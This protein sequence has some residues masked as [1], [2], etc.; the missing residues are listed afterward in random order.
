MHLHIHPR[1]M[2]MNLMGGAYSRAVGTEYV[3]APTRLDSG[4]WIL[5]PGRLDVKTGGLRE[6]T[7]CLIR[8]WEQCG[9]ACG[10]RSAVYGR[11]G[12]EWWIAGITGK[13]K[14]VWILQTPEGIGNRNRDTSRIARLTF[15]RRPFSLLRC[16]SNPVPGRSSLLLPSFHLDSHLNQPSP[17]SSKKS[18]RHKDTGTHPNRHLDPS[19]WHLY[20]V[21]RAWDNRADPTGGR[22]CQTRTSRNG[23]SE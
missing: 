21:R 13:A 2:L 11:L 8:R 15:D 22:F 20:H 7:A 3:Y 4:F 17:P 6:L 19:I 16:R 12:G 10:L 18:L 9:V 5:D 1:V 23:Q 14:D